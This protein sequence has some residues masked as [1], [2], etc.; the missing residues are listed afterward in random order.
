MR[1]RAYA[2]SPLSPLATDLFKSHLLVLHLSLWL[3]DGSQTSET[4][5]L[6]AQIQGLYVLPPCCL[7]FFLNFRWLFLKNFCSWVERSLSWLILFFISLKDDV[8]LHLVGF[9]DFDGVLRRRFD[10]EVN[11]LR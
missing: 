9:D 3:G 5:R 10:V 1:A 11:L 4:Y 8:D 6:A 7:R 2:A